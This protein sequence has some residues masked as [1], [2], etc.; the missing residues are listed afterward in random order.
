MTYRE[1]RIG[2]LIM[3]IIL[4]GVLSRGVRQE[5]QPVMVA[6][7]S[8]ISIE[9]LSKSISSIN[10]IEYKQLVKTAGA[11]EN[12]MEIHYYYKRP[13]YLRVETSGK[14]SMSIDIYKPEGMY[15]YFPK[16]SVAYYRE[17]WKDDKPVSFQLEDKLQ[18]IMIK[19]KYE[20]LKTERVSGVDCEIIRNVDEDEGS[21]YEHRIWLGKK[22]NIKLPIREEFLTDGE[23]TMTC[24]YEYISIN[25]EI[26]SSLFQLKQSEGLKIYNAEGIPKTV[27]NEKEA[28]KYVR[29]D[30]TVPKYMPKGFAINEISIIPPVKN[31]SVLITYGYNME[32][33]YYSQR[34][35][36]KNELDI[37]EN[38]KVGRVGGV[39]FAVRRLFNDSVSVRWIRNGIEFEFSGPYTLKE[40]IVKLVH[41][42]TGLWVPVE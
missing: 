30:V 19:G 6:D 38:D 34:R 20:F 3:L 16:S 23:V 42:L 36:D 29:F 9:A 41:S 25:K 2:A 32:M 17:K 27:E 35:V 13:G 4:F 10:T 7:S 39:K 24:E 33:I 15:E 40:E 37:Q 31:P 22:E 26:D 14:D 28:E 1:L 21:V 5:A 18:D 12:T 11:E 8:Y